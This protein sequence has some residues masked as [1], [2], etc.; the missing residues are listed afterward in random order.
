M[1]SHLV[2]W[3]ARRDD[4]EAAKV[5]RGL[6]QAIFAIGG[7]AP[8]ASS[9]PATFPAVAMSPWLHD[10]DPAASGPTPAAIGA[11]RMN[12][13]G[14]VMP[15][16]GALALLGVLGIGVL[17][18]GW[19]KPTWLFLIALASLAI[20]PQ[21]LWGG[22]ALGWKWG[23]H[24]SVIILAL[25]MCALRYGVRT[26]INWPI[27][28]LL[29]VLA[30]GL[31]LGDGHPKLDWLLMLESLVMLALPFSFTQVVLEPGTRRSFSTVIVLTPFLSVALGGVLHLAGIRNVFDYQAWMGEYYR[32]EGATGHPAVFATLA[33]TGFI[34]AVHE[35]TRPRRPFAAHFAVINLILV[36]LSGTRMAILASAVFLVGYT[37]ISETFREQLGRHRGKLLVGAALVAATV[38]IYASTLQNRMVA[39]DGAIEMSGRDALW[40]FF[41]EEFLL[42]PLFGRGFGSG[43]IAGEDWFSW[44]FSIPHN[45]YLHLL[46]VGGAVGFI[47]CAAAIVLW[48]RSLMLA[49]SLNDREFLTA[50]IPALLVYAVTDNVLI[51]TSALGLYAY[52]GVLMTRPAPPWVDQPV[53]LDGVPLEPDALEEATAGPSATR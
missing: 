16:A 34:V 47:L 25:A 8:L 49:V 26:N 24:Q 36:I 40:P 13:A 22:P 52:L 14:F 1:C 21:L 41:Y 18:L 19:R 43:F 17:G 44:G 15:D 37:S 53:D 2:Q 12:P 48:Y 30:L 29:A 42:S 9:G 46:V 10:D 38:V 28:A 39:G 20:R 51:Y 5:A 6:L 32:L 23:V 33:F 11:D 50:L 35:S 7:A 45:E 3:P 4:A 27:A 31:A